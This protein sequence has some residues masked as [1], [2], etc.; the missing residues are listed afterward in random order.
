V[1]T[2]ITGIL[3]G[4]LYQGFVKVQGILIELGRSKTVSDLAINVR[5]E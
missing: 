4:N 3:L 1:E 5:I 2:K